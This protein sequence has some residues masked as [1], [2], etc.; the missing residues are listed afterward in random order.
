VCPGFP[1]A[2]LS[3]WGR[4][5]YADNYAPLLEIKAKYDPENVFRFEQSLSVA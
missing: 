5:Y 1:D 3:D 2:D 4:A